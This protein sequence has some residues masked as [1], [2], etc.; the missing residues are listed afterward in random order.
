MF[1]FGYYIFSF[2]FRYSYIL[3]SL[4][5]PLPIFSSFISPCFSYIYSFL[6]AFSLFFLR[7][8]L[9]ILVLFPLLMLVSFKNPSF[10]SFSQLVTPA[11]HKPLFPFPMMVIILQWYTLLLFQPRSLSQYA[12]SS[13]SALPARSASYFLI[14][15]PYTSSF[16]SRSLIYTSSWCCS[17]SNTSSLISYTCLRRY[18]SCIFLFVLLFFVYLLFSLCVLLVIFPVVVLF[19]FLIAILLFSVPNQYAISLFPPL[20]LA[21]PSSLSLSQPLLFYLTNHVF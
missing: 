4:L 11:H 7:V 3:V 17:L 1:S 19:R 16:L 8:H 18:S 13:L 10:S 21:S 20:S 9:V 6:Q 2:L 5:I 15:Q 12:F 14:S